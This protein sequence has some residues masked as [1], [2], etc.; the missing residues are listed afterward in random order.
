MEFINNL[1]SK[2]GEDNNIMI[3]VIGIMI[4]ITYVAHKIPKQY[5]AYFDMPIVKAILLGLIVYALKINPI[6]SIL[7]A[8]A[9]I[10][11]AETSNRHGMNDS[12]G[13]YSHKLE[14]QVKTTKKDVESDDSTVDSTNIKT[15]QNVPDNVKQFYVNESNTCKIEAQKANELINV[16][17][18]II[19]KGDKLVKN[20]NNVSEGENL[21]A[22]GETLSKL[23]EELK[24]VSNER[25]MNREKI[26]EGISDVLANKK[27]YGLD[28]IN[29]CHIYSTKLNNKTSEIL[30]TANKLAGNNKQ[31][32][33]NFDATSVESDIIIDSLEDQHSKD[34]E[35]NNT[36]NIEGFNVGSDYADF[37]E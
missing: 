7:G 25:S 35:N 1:M 4:Y 36:S 27:E 8:I 21:L 2:L 29:K 6:F 18:A 23:G 9:Y 14:T 31:E 12:I 20:D 24:E 17:N 30:N 3:A 10:T 16:G 5:I 33:E 15:N 32:V 28:K 19:E 37:N 34:I 11:T 22:T 26:S 13:S